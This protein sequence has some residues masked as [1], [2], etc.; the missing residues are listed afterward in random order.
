MRPLLQSAGNKETTVQRR[1]LLLATG[2]ALP[3]RAFAQADW[4]NRPVKIVVNGGPGAPGDYTARVLAEGFAKAFGQP[5]I[6][7]NRPGANGILG[8]EYAVRQPAD[9]Y[10]L[11]L[12]FTAAQ[13][14]NP[15]I[16]DNLKYDGVRD[17]TPIAQIGSGGNILVVPTRVPA[18]DLG[19]FVA[20]LQAHKDQPLSYGSWGV[21]SGGHLSMEALLQKTGQHMTHVP[22][23][24]MGNAVTDL[25][26]GRL[27]CAFLQPATAKPLIEKGVVHPIAISGPT[28]HRDFPEVKTMTEQGVPFELASWYGLFA[29]GKLAPAIV[30]KLNTEVRRELALPELQDKWPRMGFTDFPQKSAEEFG[31]MVK[32]DARSWAEVARRGNIKVKSE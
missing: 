22:Y 2:L 32:R 20:Y 15:A 4:P 17:F 25:G 14:V 18:R 5:F 27:D 9:G 3:W 30:Q 6:V 16:Y 19:E 12:T 26:A 28:R 7:E 10:T 24:T 31:E 1:Q 13:V 29:P 21:G 8:T 11:L 23:R